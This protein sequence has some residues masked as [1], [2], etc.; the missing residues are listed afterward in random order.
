[1]RENKMSCDKCGAE[2]QNK[3]KC[4]NPNYNLKTASAK[5]LLW[6]VNEYRGNSGQRIDLCE[7]CYEKFIAFLEE[8]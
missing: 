7:E 8:G 6:A 1:M 3:M 5:I 2:I 4:Y